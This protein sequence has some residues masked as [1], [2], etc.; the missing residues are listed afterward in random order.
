[1]SAKDEAEFVAGVISGKELLLREK[2]ERL[3]AEVERLKEVVKKA[4][5][6]GH[7]DARYYYDWLNSYA[8]RALDGEE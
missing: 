8:H 1:M 7:A 6:E 4:Y 2:I 5:D 3:R